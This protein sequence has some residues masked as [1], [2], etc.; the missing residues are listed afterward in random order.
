MATSV[1][2]DVFQCLVL[3]FLEYIAFLKSGKHSKLVTRDIYFQAVFVCNIR[4]TVV[5]VVSRLD[6]SEMPSMTYPITFSKP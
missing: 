5:N 6:G 2:A 3:S 4:V 1:A